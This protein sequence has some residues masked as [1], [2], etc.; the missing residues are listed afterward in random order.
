VEE[1]DLLYQDV[2]QPDQTSIAV[3]NSVFLKGG[4]TLI[5][6]LKTQSVDVTKEPL[7]VLADAESRLAR[8]GF[9]IMGNEWL[10]PYHRDHAAITCRKG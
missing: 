4:G 10:E 5:L 8:A 7:T 3:R 6:M 2:A 9:T 1:V